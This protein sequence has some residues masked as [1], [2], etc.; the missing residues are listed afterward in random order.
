[1]GGEDKGQEIYRGTRGNTRNKDAVC[2]GRSVPESD[3]A[4]SERP[5]GGAGGT[6]SL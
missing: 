4:L 5:S 3:E 2:Y 6:H 1:M